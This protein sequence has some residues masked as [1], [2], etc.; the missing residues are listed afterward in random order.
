MVEDTEMTGSC[1]VLLKNK[2][3]LLGSAITWS[4][5]ARVV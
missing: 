5:S 4:G 2:P 1:V 3:F